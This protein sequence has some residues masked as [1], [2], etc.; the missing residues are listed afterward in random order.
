MRIKYQSPFFPLFIENEFYGKGILEPPPL[1]TVPKQANSSSWLE[2]V[3]SANENNT[4]KALE[5]IDTQ[6]GTFDEKF[7]RRF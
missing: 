4:P 7:V 6:K 1:Q 2:G 5:G 3:M